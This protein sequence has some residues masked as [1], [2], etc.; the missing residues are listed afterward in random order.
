MK[1][2]YGDIL[3]DSP[4]FTIAIN[5]TATGESLEKTHCPAVRLRGPDAGEHHI[6]YDL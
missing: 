5:A 2:R 4:S 6:R 3:G 1:N